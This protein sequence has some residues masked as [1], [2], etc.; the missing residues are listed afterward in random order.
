M[1]TEEPKKGLLG[2]RDCLTCDNLIPIQAAVVQVSNL[3]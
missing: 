2:P 3:P 1:K